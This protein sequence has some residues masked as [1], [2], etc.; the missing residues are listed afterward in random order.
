MAKPINVKKVLIII[1]KVIWIPALVIFAF[2]VGAYVGYAFM[3]KESGAS[4]LSP[5][6]WKHFFDQIKFV[7]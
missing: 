7:R 2:F 6:T 1:L 3:T 5:E 4:V